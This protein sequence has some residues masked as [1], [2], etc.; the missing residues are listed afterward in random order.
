MG[1]REGSERDSISVF[2]EEVKE[3]VGEEVILMVD[4]CTSTTSNF[5]SNSNTNPSFLGGNLF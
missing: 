2:V 3:L 4:V 1:F 5:F